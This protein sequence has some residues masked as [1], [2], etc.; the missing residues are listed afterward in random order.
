MSK[1]KTC[2]HRCLRLLKAYIMSKK[3]WMTVQINKIAFSQS[4]G[5]TKT[6]FYSC[7]IC[8]CKSCCKMFEIFYGCMKQHKEKYIPPSNESLATRCIE[9]FLIQI[10]LSLNFFY[11]AMNLFILS[12][13][14]HFT[15]KYS[16]FHMV[17]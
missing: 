17:F 10:L 14:V 16:N 15:L 9:I 7:M 11:N 4:F 1:S 12:F 6:L 2:E 5:I 3:F 13:V 8:F